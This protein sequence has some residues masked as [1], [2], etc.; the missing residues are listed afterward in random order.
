M[1]AAHTLISY[2]SCYIPYHAHLMRVFMMIEIHSNQLRFL[3]VQALHLTSCYFFAVEI[4][5]LY[6]ASNPVEE[7]GVQVPAIGSFMVPICKP[8]L[9]KPSPW[10][11]Q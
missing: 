1:H 8:M 6:I 10:H 7:I 3:I 4:S 2:S 9:E 11:M 5:S